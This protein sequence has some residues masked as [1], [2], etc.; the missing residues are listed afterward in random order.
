MS[1]RPPPIRKSLGQHFLRDQNIL[2]RIVDALGLTGSEAVVEIGPGRGGLTDLLVPRARRLVLIEY[3][4]ALAG[5]L[6]RR[7]AGRESV[8]VLCRDALTVSFA[9]AVGGEP[10]V[11][12]GNLPYYLTTPILFHALEP[13][14][15]M[16]SVFLVQ[17]EVAER[18]VAPP[19]TAAYG[20]LSI[21]VQAVTN[22]AL[23]FKVKA[24]S[25]EPPPKVES[26]VI[27]L[28]PRAVPVV[29]P[30]EEKAYGR[31]VQ[32]AFSFRRKQLRRVLRSLLEW[33]AE[34]VEKVLMKT[35]LDPTARPETLS[36]EDFARLFRATL[37]RD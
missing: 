26:A 34:E 24:G 32:E 15:A 16:R 31:F 4:R 30:V 1:H 18:I 35:G 33:S 6:E 3:D 19:N 23:L 5:L 22:P 29:A 8:S 36:P 25:F 28:E 13:P 12:I 37:T 17:R 27:R 21:N 14:R 7:F 11:V 10:F 9:D 2:Q 20:A